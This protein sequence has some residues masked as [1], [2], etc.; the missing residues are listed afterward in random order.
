MPFTLYIVPNI[1]W[2]SLS[3]LVPSTPKFVIHVPKIGTPFPVGRR[4]IS[5]IGKASPFILHRVPNIGRP[6][7]CSLVPSTLKFVVHLPNIETPF[8]VDFGFCY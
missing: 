2:P 5:I 8:P 1:G 7:L 4:S 3:S 6:S